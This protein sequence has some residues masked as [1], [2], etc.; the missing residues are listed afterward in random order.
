[1]QPLLFGQDFNWLLQQRSSVLRLDCKN[2]FIHR[3]LQNKLNN[4]LKSYVISIL[5][6]WF[7]E[8]IQDVW[9]VFTVEALVGWDMEGKS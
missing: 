1:M 8:Y 2:T 6:Q 5:Q 7:L 3:Q 9:K 4:I